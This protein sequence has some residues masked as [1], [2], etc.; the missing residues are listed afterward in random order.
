MP[1]FLDLETTG[2][3]STDR[4][5]SIGFIHDDVIHYELISPTCK[6]GIKAMSLHHITNEKLQKK[7]LFSESKAEALLETFNETKSVLVAHNAN[8]EL[9]FLAK[10]GIYWQ[11]AVI[12]TLRC[13]KHLMNDLESYALQY[14]RYELKLYKDEEV[15]ATDLKISLQEHHALSD[16]LWVKMLYDYLLELSD[17]S[18]LI[19]MT[20]RAVLLEKFSFGKYKDR[21]IEEVVMQERSYIEWLLHQEIDEDLRYSLRHY[22]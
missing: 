1:L 9:E 21:Y 11:G 3:E 5:C 12:D 6:V 18:S 8:F 13:A 14:L 10:E 17:E 7:A 19:E 4:L 22:L 15:Y 16:A 2:L 20:K